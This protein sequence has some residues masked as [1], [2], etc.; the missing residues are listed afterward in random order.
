MPPSFLRKFILL[1][2]FFLSLTSCKK[3]NTSNNSEA[4]D[5]ESYPYRNL[6]DEFKEYWYSGE[7]E[8]S[9]YALKMSRYGELRDGTAALVYVTE[10]FLPRE[11]VKANDVNET[12]VS[13]LKLNT[14]K[15][16]VTGI[17]PYS[18]MTSI[19]Y[20]LGH[21]SH[22]IKVA[23]S[24]QEWCGQIY[25]QLNNRGDF[26]ITQH[27]YLEGE[28]DRSFHLRENLLEDELW[29]QLR[30]NPDSLPTGKKLVVPSLEYLNLNHR[31]FKAY[32]AELTKTDTMYT[33]E[34]PKLHRRL[35]IHF[36]P[37][38][39]FMVN[40]WQETIPVGKNGETQTSTATKI[41]TIKT[42]YWKQNAEKFEYLRDSL[43]L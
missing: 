39:P 6:N 7:A 27:A 21:Q 1:T 29:T 26:A 14:T 20:P 23:S 18:I 24:S 35:R 32:E 5:K 41:K 9:S 10:D 13:V 43:G 42:A 31:E 4:Y 37:D 22:A 38:F 3:N 30:I 17:Y 25:T 34:Y 28:A 12:N 8:I 33:V 2:V 15:K 16:F 11:E 36:K 40:G 19:F